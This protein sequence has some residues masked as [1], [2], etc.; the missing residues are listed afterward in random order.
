[1]L[2]AA[3]GLFPAWRLEAE[4]LPGNDASHRLFRR[5]GYRALS[6]TRYVSDPVAEATS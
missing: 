3:R 6:S 5:V 4:V 1:M 2:A